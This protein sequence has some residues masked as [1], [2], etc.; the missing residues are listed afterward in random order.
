[1]GMI[2]E[3]ENGKVTGEIRSRSF[4]LYDEDAD[5]MVEYGWS[6]LDDLL[7]VIEKIIH[8]KLTLGVR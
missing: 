2:V 1:M 4:K 6:E 3:S 8:A 5:G 7:Q